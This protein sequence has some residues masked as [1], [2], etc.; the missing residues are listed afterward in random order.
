MKAINT[1][2]EALIIDDKIVYV[3]SKN[4][5]V[6]FTLKDKTEEIELVGF[7]KVVLKGNQL[8]LIK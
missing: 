3:N 8:E 5:T 4:A 7:S 2:A 1:T 6:A